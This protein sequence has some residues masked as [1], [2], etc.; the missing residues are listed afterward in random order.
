MSKIPRT[1]LNA[2]QIWDGKTWN[3]TPEATQKSSKTRSISLSPAP[4]KRE[5]DT[6]GGGDNSQNAESI[7]EPK[8]LTE[9]QVTQIIKKRAL[10]KTIFKEEKDFLEFIN[11]FMEALLSRSDM[12]TWETEKEAFKELIQQYGVS[13]CMRYFVHLDTA[14]KFA[15]FQEVWRENMRKTKYFILKGQQFTILEISDPAKFCFKRMRTLTSVKPTEN[16]DEITVVKGSDVE[17]SSTDEESA[18]ED[19]NLTFEQLVQ[20]EPARPYKNYL[21]TSKG[22]GGLRKKFNMIIQFLDSLVEKNQ[23]S[24]E[25]N[26]DN[27]VKQN[28]KK[29]QEQY[30]KIEQRREQA[31]AA[32]SEKT[33]AKDTY[34]D[35]IYKSYLNT[36]DKI[37]KNFPGIQIEGLFMASQ[38]DNLDSPKNFLCDFCASKPMSK[39]DLLKHMAKTHNISDYEPEETVVSPVIKKKPIRVQ[40]PDFSDGSYNPQERGATF[41]TDSNSSSEEENDRSRPKTRGKKGRSLKEQPMTHFEEQMHQFLEIQRSMAQIQ[42]SSLLKIDEVCTVFD[43]QKYSPLDQLK[44]YKN[45]RLEVD[46]LTATMERLGY[47]QA[48]QYQTLKSRVKNEARDMILEDKPNDS[49]FQKSLQTLDNYFWSKNL[50]V[51]NIMHQFKKLPK[52]DNS[53][54]TKVANFTTEAISL[55]TQLEEL[56]GV[57]SENEIP[58]YLLFSEILVSKFNSEAKKHYQSLIKETN[59]TKLGHNLTIEDLKNVLTT[60]QKAMKHR[61]FD[62]AFMTEQIPKSQNKNKR[63]KS[64]EK[65]K[66]MKETFSFSTETQN[67]NSGPK[68]RCDPVEGQMCR[69][70]G[71]QATLQ[72][73]S[74]YQGFHLYQAAC[75]KLRKLSYTA[76]AKWVEEQGITCFHCFSVEHSN[77]NCQF[78]D[79]KCRRIVKIGDKAPQKCNKDHHVALHD[80]TRHGKIIKSSYQKTPA[81]SVNQD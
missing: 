17:L 3:I 9:E 37:G 51:R 28:L 55:M 53:S 4:T 49:S 48:R 20:K 45:W 66:V 43:P 23:T 29:L 50:H 46:D 15:Q 26:R 5:G 25:I 61:E 71:C 77:K 76:V 69:V 27:L 2:N 40:N 65:Q 7:E 75:P 73:G 39:K 34:L 12:V 44:A 10:S 58:I 70:P 67:K 22:L 79:T 8:Q 19:E 74:R 31:T 14:F 21:K 78:K 11:Q 32:L 18:S 41:S 63:S 42:A 33:R 72:K 54:A 47:S 57:N 36:K 52:M 35:P 62:K 68:K 59:K 80:Q 6:V 24:P 13:V 30:S 1:P 38:Q 16:P 56:F 60:T 81:G 64:E